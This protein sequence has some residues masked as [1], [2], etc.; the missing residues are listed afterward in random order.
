MS[1]QGV[2]NLG[3]AD[4][5]TSFDAG[6]FGLSPSDHFGPMVWDSGHHFLA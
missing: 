2:A 6:Q 1:A 4:D 3:F 5:F